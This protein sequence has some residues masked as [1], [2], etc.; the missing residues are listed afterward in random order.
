MNQPQKGNLLIAEP[1]LLDNYFSRSVVL[2]CEHQTEMGSVGFIVNRILSE[3]LEDFFPELENSKPV[4][5]FFG[6]PV[7]SDRLNFIHSLGDQIKDGVEILDGVFWGGDFKLVKKLL[8][9]NELDLSKIKFFLGYSSWDKEQLSKELQDNSWIISTS[10]NELIFSENET[11]IWKQSLVNLGGDYAVM[12]N[13][14]IHP[15]LN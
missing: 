1:F 11:E 6:G 13:Y 4:P 5:V 2:L 8:L 10:K 15:S 12:S 7:H 14:P 9:K 3:K